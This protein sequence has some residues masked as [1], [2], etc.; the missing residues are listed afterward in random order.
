MG[1]VLCGAPF[2]RFPKVVL[3]TLGGRG[4]GLSRELIDRDEGRQSRNRTFV[5]EL[6]MKGL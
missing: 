3:R 1:V 2:Q 4:T 5:G 6:W